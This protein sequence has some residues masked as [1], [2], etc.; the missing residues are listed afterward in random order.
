[1][2]NGFLSKG[3]DLLT[4]R[5]TNILSAAFVIMLTVI[6]SQLLGLVRQ[7]LLVGIFGASNELGIYLYSTQLPD[8]LFQLTIAA[9]LSSAF[10]PVFSDYLTKGKEKEGH[11]MAS[12]LLSLGFIIFLVFSFFLAFFAKEVLQIFNLGSNFSPH[13]MELMANLMRIVIFGQLLF[14]IG[15]FFTALLQSYNHFFVPGIAAAL[16]NLG[17]IIGILVFYPFVGIYSAAIGVL[18]GGLIFISVQIPLARKVGFRFKPSFAY[19]HSDGIKK[20]RKTLP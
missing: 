14:I 19:I 5:Q 10:I 8:T 2:R 13:D 18:L 15:T 11:K 3:L 1:M 16:Y 17:I 12:T 20:N 7:R 6:I 9:A 4:R